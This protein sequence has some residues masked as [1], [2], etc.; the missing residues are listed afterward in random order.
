M[1]GG[2]KIEGE[3]QSEVWGRFRTYFYP[4]V[5]GSKYRSASDVRCRLVDGIAHQ[6]RILSLTNG[7]ISEV[8]SLIRFLSHTLRASVSYL[9]CQAIR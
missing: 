8:A 2:L 1:N 3:F 9:G 6:D 7:G 5:L 4:I